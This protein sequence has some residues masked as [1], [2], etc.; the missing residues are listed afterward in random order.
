MRISE[1]RFP[2][3]TR[4]EKKTFL[5]NR[6]LNGELYCMLQSFAK[7]P[8]DNKGHKGK[9]LVHK[10]D[11][12][13]Q[14]VI[15]EK[16]GIKSTKTV[17]NHLAALK[18]AGYIIDN[19]KTYEL[20]ELDD[21]YLLVPVETAA[22]LWDN[23]K[24]HVV[25][26]YLYLGQRYKYATMELHRGYYDFSYAEIGEHLGLNIKNNSE[27]YRV[28]GNAL[29]LLKNSGLVDYEEVYVNKVPYKRLTAFST[30]VRGASPVKIASQ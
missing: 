9:T 10:K 28:I 29:L 19:G 24:D 7:S 30:D 21:M 12:P 6:K 5:N 8:F 15:C 23:C 18:E 16:L 26:L 11:L 25:K 4:V 17:R 27:G 22:Y 13:N 3:D 2:A 14:D 20:P 1:R